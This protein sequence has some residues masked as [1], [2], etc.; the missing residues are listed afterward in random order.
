MIFVMYT[1]VNIVGTQVNIV[2]VGSLKVKYNPCLINVA[3]NWSES[4]KFAN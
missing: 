1:Q 3:V 2:N 4:V